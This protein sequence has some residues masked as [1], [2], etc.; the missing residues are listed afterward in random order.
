MLDLILMLNIA[1]F[2]LVDFYDDICCFSVSADC[3]GQWGPG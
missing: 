1:M 3:S 2:W